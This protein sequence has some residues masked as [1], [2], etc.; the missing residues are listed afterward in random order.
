[1][2]RVTGTD[3]GLLL[4]ARGLS[5]VYGT[6][7]NRNTAV[8]GVDLDV[9]HGDIYVLMGLSGS[10]KS[11]V[12]RMLNRLVEPTTGTVELDGQDLAAL[13]PRD[14][15]E[16]RNRRISMVFQHFALF[17]H[18]TVRQ[19]AAYGLRLRGM[20]RAEAFA[21]ADESLE[22]VGLGDW[23]DA[24]PKELSGGMKQRV[25]LAR[26][27]STEADVLLMDEPFSALDPLIR[28]DMQD[29]LLKLAG[30]LGRTVVFVTHDLNEAMR[31]GDTITLLTRGHVA[32]TGTAVDILNRP[33]DDY[34]RRFIGEVDR[35]RVLTA[36]DIMTAPGSW[37]GPRP[38]LEVASDEL[39]SR[40]ARRLGATP[41]A[42]VLDGDDLV[43]YVSSGDVL[44]AI[45]ETVGSAA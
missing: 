6:G 9:H 22:I 30:D 38:R 4:R 20:P 10:G 35:S 15:R 17:P 3:R 7:A 8:E 2:A 33:A 39:L 37:T 41:D 11:T 34:V 1:M 26:A 45:G 27:L 21:K 19:N 42:A 36:R 13:G 29:L 40:V 16:V 28:R 23:G 31:L 24:K 44:T 25:G 5:K 18:R 14:L 32:Q 43:G 12:L